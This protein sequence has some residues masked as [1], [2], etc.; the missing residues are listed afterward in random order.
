M[1]INKIKEEILSEYNKGNIVFWGIDE[2][3]IMPIVKFLEQPVDG[4]LYDLNRSE[5]IAMSFFDDPKWINDYAIC[6][7]I[8]ELYSRSM[9][10]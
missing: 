2:L 3:I 9:K 10:A 7:V 1:T 4:I 5:E 6:Q 8:R